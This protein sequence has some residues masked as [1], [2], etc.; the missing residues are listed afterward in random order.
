VPPR[1]MATVLRGVVEAGVGVASCG[2]G[3]SYAASASER[4]S[5]GFS[6]G[7]SRKGI[8]NLT[9]R[10]SR[11]SPSSVISAANHV[12]SWNGKP[13]LPL[14]SIP[15]P[16]LYN[17]NGSV[18]SGGAPSSRAL[19]EM[20]MRDS[21]SDSRLRIFSGTANKALAQVPFPFPGTSSSVVILIVSLDLV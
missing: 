9:L 4:Q 2:V 13:G 18:L 21:R 8:R 3:S 6:Q 10:S 11:C 5:G 15:D 7:A 17:P 20:G 12:N 14:L 1:A 19:S 16:T